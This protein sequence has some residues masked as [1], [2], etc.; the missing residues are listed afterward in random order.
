MEKVGKDREKG[1]SETNF[2]LATFSLP[3]NPRFSVC[4]VNNDDADDSR[5]ILEKVRKLLLSFRV[6]RS[7]VVLRK[8]QRR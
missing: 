5:I 7:T 2:N 8:P 6:Y 3:E 4:Q 1:E